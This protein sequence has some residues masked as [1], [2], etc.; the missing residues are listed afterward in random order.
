MRPIDWYELSK[1]F[2]E[3]NESYKGR[4]ASYQL[5]Q[6][7]KERKL[8]YLNEQ[9]ECEENCSEKKIKGKK[10]K[11]YSKTDLRDLREELKSDLQDAKKCLKGADV[12]E[13]NKCKRLVDKI[14][15]QLDCVVCEINYRKAHKINEAADVPADSSLEDDYIS[16]KDDEK[17]DD[18]DVEEV[19]MTAIIVTVKK[20]DLEKVKEEMT[21][22]GID[23]EYIEIEDV[24]DKE[25]DDEVDITVDAHE[26]LKL[27]DW[28]KEKGIDLEEKIGGEII[29]DE[30]SDDADDDAVNDKGLEDIFKDLDDEDEENK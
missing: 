24:E 6:L 14:S 23:E 29:A 13:I 25:D 20:G 18:N 30:D 12:K 5:K 27:K 19:E 16:R 28:L 22:A 21:D 26:V 4:S 1:M 9:S 2:V 17:K 8:N 15:Y 7:S 10:L 3:T 11:S